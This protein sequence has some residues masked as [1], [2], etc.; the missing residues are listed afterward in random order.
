M[1]VFVLRKQDTGLEGLAEEIGQATTEDVKRQAAE[2]L[3]EALNEIKTQFNALEI[4]PDNFDK[5][6]QTIEEVINGLSNLLGSIRAVQE[7]VGQQPLRKQRGTVSL[8]TDTDVDL[9][10]KFMSTVAKIIK[11]YP[12][13]DNDT[14]DAAKAAIDE[15]RKILDQMEKNIAVIEMPP[16]E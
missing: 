13:I 11:N 14:A 1:R 3:N 10:D 6:A 4:T 12:P 2:K 5:A 8:I 15:M 7:R 16:E 9:V